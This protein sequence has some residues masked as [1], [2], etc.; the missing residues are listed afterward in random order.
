MNAAY[1]NRHA[2]KIYESIGVLMGISISYMN[3][4]NVKLS[5]IY[6]AKNPN[7]LRFGSGIMIKSIIYGTLW[8]VALSG[9]CYDVFDSKMA[10]NRHLIPFSVYGKW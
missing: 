10:F 2:T 9:I 6:D 5:P 4:A 7:Y 3:L 1:F 8:P